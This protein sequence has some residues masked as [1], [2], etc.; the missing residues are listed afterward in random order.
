MS[1]GGTWHVV[2]HAVPV[3]WEESD[4]KM[5]K[6][7]QEGFPLRGFSTN[8]HTVRIRS[9]HAMPPFISALTLCPFLAAQVKSAVAY[10]TEI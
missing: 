1:A 5:V 8:I 9:R 2:W 3:A 4:A 10:R 6:N 7:G